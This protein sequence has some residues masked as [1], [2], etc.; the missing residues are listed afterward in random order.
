MNVMT[1]II[2]HVDHMVC[3]KDIDEYVCEDVR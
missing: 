3:I 1:V 2:I